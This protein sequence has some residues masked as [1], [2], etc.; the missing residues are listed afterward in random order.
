MNAELLYPSQ[1]AVENSVPGTQMPTSEIGSGFM[2]RDA[3]SCFTQ[4]QTLTGHMGQT[5]DMTYRR[6]NGNQQAIKDPIIIP[7][8]NA[9]VDTRLTV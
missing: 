3:K 4:L 7:E 2:K 1:K 5:G 8:N 9:Y 6:K